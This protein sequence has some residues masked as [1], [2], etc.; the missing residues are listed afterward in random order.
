[1]EF[2]IDELKLKTAGQLNDNEKNYLRENQDKLNAE[3]REAYS[4]FLVAEE[5]PAPE[6]GEST[7]VTPPAEETP[8]PEV[9]PAPE[10][11][12]EATPTPSATP[13]YQF[14]TEEEAKAF[15]AKQIEESEKAKKA[16]IEK[17]TTPEQKKYIED[18]WN[19]DNWNVVARKFV[20]I[21]KNEIRAEKEQEE[22]EKN[23]KMY[24]A[25]WTELVTE[26]KVPSLETNEGKKVHKEIVSLM[27]GFGKK[28]F[29]EGYAL[30]EKTQGKAPEATPAPTPTPEATTTETAPI[31]EK[32]KAA[33]ARQAATKIGGQN[34]GKETTSGKAPLKPLT[35]EEMQ[36]KSK[37]K[38]LREAI[39]G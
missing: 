34:T 4:S 23:A 39:N 17:A 1:M 36:S 12:P 27:L 38:I 21:A 24:Q 30:W 13:A 10:A 29:K 2:N 9:T 16:A 7:E 37:A 25:Q 33:S 15:V 8:A 3:D 5:T 18:N 11:T 20:D 19:P 35:W 6:G 32:Q 14:Q 28:T 26:K 31:T 22:S